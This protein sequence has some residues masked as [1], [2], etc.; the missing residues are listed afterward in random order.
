[1]SPLHVTCRQPTGLLSK[2]RVRRKFLLD[3]AVLCLLS[4]RQFLILAIE[5][6][7]GSHYI[8]QSHVNWCATSLRPRSIPEIVRTVVDVVQPETDVVQT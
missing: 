2:V 3:I 4:F 6:Q 7:S 5:L 1:M 8:I